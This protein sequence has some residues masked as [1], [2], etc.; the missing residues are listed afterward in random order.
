[1]PS[2][3]EEFLIRHIALHGPIDV[4]QFMQI[5]LTHP[6]HGYYMNRDPFGRGGDF[7]TAPEV[8]QMFGEM[9]GVWVADIWQQMGAPDEFIL[10]ECGPGR[11]TLMAD[12]LRATKH[13]SGFH[14]AA[15]IYLIEV[16]PAL[17]EVQKKTLSAYDVRWCEDVSVLPEH[18]P[19]IVI[20]NEFLDALPFRQLQKSCGQWCERVVM[21]EGGFQF[22]LRPVAAQ[23]LKTLPAFLLQAEEGAIYEFSLPRENFVAALSQRIARQKGVALLIDYGHAVQGAGDT[24]QA[25]KDNR[26]SDVFAAIGQSDLTSHVDFA[27][28]VKIASAAGLCT[29]GPQEQGAFLCA[30][31][32]EQRAHMLQHKASAEQVVMLKNSLHRLTDSSAMGALFKVLCLSRVDGKEFKPAGF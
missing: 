15:K 9:I 16:S 29:H 4:G 1:M 12:M 18:A 23:I 14:A 3:L 27:A 19:L 20:A 21:Y 2:P 11:G 8:S 10:A 26:Y 24:F 17:K 7:I 22:V 28:L 25:L 30:L 32:I 13:I 5:A 6:Q 31:G